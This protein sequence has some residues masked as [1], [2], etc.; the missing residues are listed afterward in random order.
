MSTI[1]MADIEF[2]ERGEWALSA[3]LSRPSGIEPTRRYVT[4]EDGP[5]P[6]Y[7]D[8]HVHSDDTVGTN[9]TSYN[10]CYGRDVA[11]LDILGYTANDFNITEARW[12]RAVELVHSLNE[13]GRFVCFPGTEWCGNSSGGGDRNVVFLHG[14]NPEFPFDNQGRMVRSIDWN[15]ATQGGMRPGTW[16][17][18]EL[19]AA[20]A[21]DP[22]GHL[23]IP[24]VGGRRCI[25]D[26]H[27]PQLERLIEIGSAWGQFPWVYADALSRGY[28]LGAAANSDE[29]QGRCGGGVPGTAVFGCRGGLTGV[30][31]RAS[32]A[33][34]WRAL[35][36][37]GAHS[38]PLAKEPSPPSHMGITSWDQRGR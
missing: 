20:Y 17:V 3:S 15:E 18:D 2:D 25:L 23:L 35:C 38:P 36:E 12:N 31:P 34:R 19:Y 22:E 1:A 8:L 28:R 27:H 30:S 32:T 4:V 11:G 6:L 29:H 26:W 10:L 16:S 9:D 33:C 5:A 14:R 7:A 37:H 13:D 21:K 24:H